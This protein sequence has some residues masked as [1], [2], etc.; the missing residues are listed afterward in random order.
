MIGQQY[1]F[2]S[3]QLTMN[4]TVLEV[5]LD[6]EDNWCI[7]DETKCMYE[8]KEKAKNYSKGH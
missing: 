5:V 3:Y 1:L 4:S 7:D 2:V 8:T 6:N